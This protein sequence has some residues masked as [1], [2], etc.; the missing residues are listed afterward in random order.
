MNF[1]YSMFYFFLFADP[2]A[3]IAFFE[4][5]KERVSGRWTVINSS[6]KN[7]VLPFAPFHQPGVK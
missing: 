1:I 5:A 4:G 2:E 6:D 7:N 3:K